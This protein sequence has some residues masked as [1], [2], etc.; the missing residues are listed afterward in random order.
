M[1][2]WVVYMIGLICEAYA[3]WRAFFD[4]MDGDV[5]GATF[6]LLVAVYL[7]VVAISLRQIYS[8]QSL[9]NIVGR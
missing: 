6:W 1:G 2:K 7:G 3:L 5:G 8:G 4:K 9:T